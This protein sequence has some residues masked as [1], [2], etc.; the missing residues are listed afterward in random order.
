MAEIR[1]PLLEA[2]SISKHQTA[3]IGPEGQLTYYEFDQ[4]VSITAARLAAARFM[5]GER[6]GLFLSADW[7]TPVLLLAL[8]RI[9]AVACPL[10]PDWSKER[11]ALALGFLSG[12]KAIVSSIL[13]GC[14]SGTG[15]RVLPAEDAAILGVMGE[16][17]GF[18]EMIPIDRPATLAFLSGS[19]TTTLRAGL[20]TYGNHYYSARG[21]NANI[22]VRSGDRWLLWEPLCRAEG[23]AAVFRCLVSGGTLAIPGPVRDLPQDLADGGISHV[24]LSAADLWA[25]VESG[26]ALRRLAA[27]RAVIVSAPV[28][29]ALL[30]GAFSARIPLYLSYGIPEMASQ[31]TAVQPDSPPEKRRTAGRILKYRNLRL[32][33]DGEI[34]V[35]GETLFSGYV[36][37]DHIR[38]ALDADGWFA[39][40]DLG[41][42]DFE[43]YLTVTGRKPR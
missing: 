18:G 26:I 13:M 17:G 36:E 15:A 40:G 7:R 14:L 43:G 39:T 32:A 42:L 27:L 10:D 6:V 37:G 34:L 29:P 3:L 21:A 20:Q 38:T 24:S 12:A 16:E 8:L 2:A 5:A 23:L 11:L 41:H 28:E 31:I 9:G 35:R 4:L 30:E 19:D 22:R 25:L 1:C 33:D